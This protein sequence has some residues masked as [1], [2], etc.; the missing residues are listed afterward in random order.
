M[1]DVHWTPNDASALSTIATHVFRRYEIDPFSEE[2]INNL[3][4]GAENN[5]QFVID[6]INAPFRKEFENVK[7]INKHNNKT[8]TFNRT[9]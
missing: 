5:T 6:V 1:I 8:P 3:K 2:S 7:S 4:I 9:T